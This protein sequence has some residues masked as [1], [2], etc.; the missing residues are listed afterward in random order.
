MKPYDLMGGI[1]GV[2]GMGGGETW[3]K[4]LPEAAAAR[5]AFVADDDLV[6]AGLP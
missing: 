3:R 5:R 1:S 2:R 6:S 4:V